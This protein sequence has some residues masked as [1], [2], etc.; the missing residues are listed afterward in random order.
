MRPVSPQLKEVADRS[1]QLVAEERLDENAALLRDAVSRFPDDP[2]VCLLLTWAASQML[3]RGH[4]DEAQ[5]W[6]RR[7]YELAPDDFE[8]TAELVHVVG[9]L[10]WAR[11]REKEAE[12][13]LRMAYELDP[14]TASH[15]KLLE[16]FLERTGVRLREALQALRAGE[17][18]IYDV[19]DAL[20]VADVYIPHRGASHDTDV[21]LATTADDAV[22]LFSSADTMEASMGPGQAHLHVPFEALAWPEGTDAVVDPDSD[23]SL[24]L[25][26]H[27]LTRPG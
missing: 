23:W 5:A 20:L 3:D 4:L 24:R 26:A 1:Q 16:R 18:N 27:T 10:A 8:F 12:E 15:G 7:V 14:E 13:M 22:P 9:R 19:R 6:I 17:G 25:P 2:E 21:T 11:G